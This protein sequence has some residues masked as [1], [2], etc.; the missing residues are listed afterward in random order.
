MSCIAP[1]ILV[2]SA[3]SIPRRMGLC[4]GIVAIIRRTFCRATLSTNAAFLDERSEPP[5]G[6]AADCDGLVMVLQSGDRV[7]QAEVPKAAGMRRRNWIFM[8]WRMGCGIRQRVFS[9][10]FPAVQS[11]ARASHAQRGAEFGKLPL[12]RHPLIKRRNPGSAAR[13]GRQA[14]SAG[15]D[16]SAEGR[17]FPRGGD[18]LTRGAEPVR[19]QRGRQGSPSF[20]SAGD[21]SCR[22]ICGADSRRHRRHHGGGGRVPET[23]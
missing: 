23:A 13:R 2:S 20:S 16:A 17:L 10:G 15:Q 1:T 12:D 8:S 9:A 4:L 21:R 14:G 11:A 5:A 18:P 7:L 22:R 3:L 6:V 19:S